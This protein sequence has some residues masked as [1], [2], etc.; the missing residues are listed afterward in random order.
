MFAR[1]EVIIPLPDIDVAFPWG[2]LED[3]YREFPIEYDLD[4]SNFYRK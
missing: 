2:E 4:F 1:F 3:G